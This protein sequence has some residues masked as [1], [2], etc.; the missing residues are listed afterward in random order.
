MGATE[1]PLECTGRD[2]QLCRARAQ[3]RPLGCS[4]NC[5]QFVDQRLEAYFVL[6]MGFRWSLL[7]FVVVLQ[8]VRVL[9]QA[10]ARPPL[11]C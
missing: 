8:V 7:L 10:Q 4:R 1:I 9:T 5:G 11:D 2:Q 3:V 6:S